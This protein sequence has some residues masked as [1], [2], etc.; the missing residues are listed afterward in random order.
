MQVNPR[1]S[2]GFLAENTDDCML[3]VD[4]VNQDLSMLLV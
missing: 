4:L 3:F 2:L 1:I